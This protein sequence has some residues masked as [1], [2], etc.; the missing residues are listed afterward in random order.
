MTKPVLDLSLYLVL[1]PERCGGING[2]VQTAL[3][4]VSGG[5]TMVQLRSTEM[6]KRQWYQAA[7]ALKAA[8]DPLQVPLI[9]NDQ[10]DV[11]LAVDAAGVHVG[12]K[13]L[14]ADVV[15]R[16][17]GPDKLLG[18]SAS[19]AAQIAM[20]PLDDV[21]Y[22]GVGPVFPT[23]SKPDADP[24]LGM[25][26]LADLLWHK[27]CPVVAIGG[28]T[29]DTAA[30]AIRCGADGIAVVSAICGQPEPA[31]AAETLRQRVESAR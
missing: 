4:A 31:T 7:M 5:V 22:L 11:A 30:D 29:A 1:D 17:I 18:L 13:D 28:I 27:P 2:M 23:N 24:A 14:P 15:R 25:L 16:L 21:D 3:E 20:A 6:K 26:L 10:I 9:I 19:N 12:Q 8:L